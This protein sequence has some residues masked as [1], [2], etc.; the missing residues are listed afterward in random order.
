[1]AFSGSG[2]RVNPN[3]YLFSL[4][5]SE[6]R[7]R[8]TRVRETERENVTRVLLYSLIMI[9]GGYRLLLMS[10]QLTVTDPHSTPTDAPCT[11]T[12]RVQ[13]VQFST[14]R[15]L[16]MSLQLT[17]LARQPRG[18]SGHSQLCRGCVRLYLQRPAPTCTLC[19]APVSHAGLFEG[20]DV[21]RQETF[22]R[23][24]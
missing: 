19:R 17:L 23:P 13:R 15:F 3:Y 22:V 2:V 14:N 11:P 20:D 9:S 1:M 12:A 21:A 16:L 6:R 10:L 4:R 8:E 18:C 7:V 24:R 5:A